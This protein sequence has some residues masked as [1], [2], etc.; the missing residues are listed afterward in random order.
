MISVMATILRPSSAS[1]PLLVLNTEIISAM[2]FSPNYRTYKNNRKDELQQQ[3]SKHQIISLT[4]SDDVR[5]SNVGSCL[6]LFIYSISWFSSTTN[7][8]QF[9]FTVW[10]ALFYS[11]FWLLNRKWVSK[12]LHFQVIFLSHHLTLVWLINHKITHW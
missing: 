8:N 7:P 4:K 3:R 5:F 10:V 2:S 12:D 9:G 6:F 11:S 1:W